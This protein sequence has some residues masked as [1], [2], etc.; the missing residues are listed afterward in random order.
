MACE[1]EGRWTV[2]SEVGQSHNRQGSQILRL[3]SCVGNG[4]KHS[5]SLQQFGEVDDVGL[6]GNT[7]GETW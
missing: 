5:K 2:V 6:V 3:L 4:T 1:G 7:V